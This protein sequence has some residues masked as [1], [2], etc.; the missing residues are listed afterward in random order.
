MTEREKELESKIQRQRD[1]EIAREWKLERM[2][3]CSSE[4][5]ERETRGKITR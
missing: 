4:M 3:E 5:R 2:K 1:S